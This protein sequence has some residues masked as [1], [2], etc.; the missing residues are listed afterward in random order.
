MQHPK[1]SSI[2]C[3]KQYII[4]VNVIKS[5]FY[6]TILTI[7]ALPVVCDVDFIVITGSVFRSVNNN[8][9]VNSG[10]SLFRRSLYRG[11][12]PYILLQLLLGKRLLIVIPGILF[13]RRS[14]YRGFAPYILLQLLLGKRFVDRYTRNIVKPKP[15]V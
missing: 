7:S 13:Y 4:A 12:A 1:Y 3:Q 15:T 2:T 6:Y 9:I 10:I 8:P 14:L 11:F 5:L